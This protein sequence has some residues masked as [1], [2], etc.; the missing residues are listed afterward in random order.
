MKIAQVVCTFPPYA[1]GMGNSVYNMSEALAKNGHQVTVFTINYDNN[2]TDYSEKTPKFA[3]KRLDSI[4]KIGNA[5]VLPQLFWRLRNFDIIHLHYPFYGAIL[6]IILRKIFFP[7]STNLVLHYHMDTRASGV[8]AFIFK[9]YQFILLPALIKLSSCVTC[10]SLDYLKH[11]YIAKY[12][13]KHPEKFKRVSFGVNLE[14][15][16]SYKDHVNKFRREKVVLFV[17]GLDKAH[18]FKGVHNLIK[19]VAIL[20]KEID[21]I[22]LSI[23]G[24]GELIKYYKKM[25]HDLRIEKTV[26][27]FDMI[28]DA[29]LVDYYNY[30]DVC[31]L[32]STDQS[33][34]FGLVLLEAM[35]CGK[36]VIASN[37]PGVRSVFKNNEQ[38]LLVKPNDVKDLTEKLQIILTDNAMAKRMGESAK[39]LVKSKYTWEKVAEK[40]NVIYHRIKYSPKKL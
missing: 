34:A 17:G 18:Y 26:R 12:Q 16:V 40:L 8:K 24:R 39:V 5:A 27:F 14:Q 9:I 29:D 32:P 25:V 10:A 38:G 2:P 23:V 7:T 31:V 13:K 1:G 20:K 6:P 33:E 28:D 22:K 19:A 36:P 35:A 30:C 11:S 4:I 37:L 21:N 15:F 3:I